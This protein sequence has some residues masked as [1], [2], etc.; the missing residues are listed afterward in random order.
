MN[1]GLLAMTF[2]YSL[3]Y[4]SKMIRNTKYEILN[5]V[6]LYW[7]PVFAWAGVIFYFSSI[8]SLE[9][10]FAVSVDWALRKAAHIG[11]YAVL[12]LLIFR[13]L[14]N[15]H[16]IEIKKALLWAAVFALGYALSDEFHQLYV[17]GRQGRLRDVGID[18]V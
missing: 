12:T 15:G 11:V 5:T 8:P 6:F 4:N 7:I 13:A 14:H 16:N 3:I 9:S 1:G 10:G 18:I 2:F 17:P